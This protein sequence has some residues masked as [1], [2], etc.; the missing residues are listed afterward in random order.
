MQNYTKEFAESKKQTI[1]QFLKEITD[2]KIFEE[3]KKLIEK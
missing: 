2:A 3:F 1:L